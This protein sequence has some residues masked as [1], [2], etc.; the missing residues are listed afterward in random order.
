M[1]DNIVIGQYYPVNSSIH[2]LDPR[3]KLGAVFMYIIVLLILTN[4]WGYVFSGICLGI[5]IIL[6]KIPF[7]FILKGLK[8]ISFIIAFT[9][10]LNVL[11]TPGERE[12][13]SFYFI[14]ITVEGILHS[15]KM[16]TRLFLLILGS[17]LLTLTTSPIQLTD[18]IEFYLR[19]YKKIGLPSHEIAMMMTIAL[20]FIPILMTEMDK[21]MKAQ[22]ARGADFATGNIMQK[23]K[24]LI[25]LLV[26]LFISAFRRADDLALAMEARCYRGDY[27]RTKMKILKLQKHD[28]IAISII[29][30]YVI[31]AL[32][33][34]Y[35]Y[36]PSL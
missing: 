34:K 11:F 17:S 32:L 20:R 24:S 10:I 3:V 29:F 35:L 9:A 31:S 1:F 2:L 6:S 4:P 22:M 36:F 8:G 14:N 33:T 25:P 16:V 19:P 28:Y 12:I 18:A 27:N 26:P 21:I 13:Y 30:I 15:I 7:K 23:A 5:V